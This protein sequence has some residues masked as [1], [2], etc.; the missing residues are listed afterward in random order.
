MLNLHLFGCIILSEPDFPYP[1]KPRPEE[2]AY[3]SPEME[4]PP[5]PPSPPPPPPLVTENVSK[6]TCQI[7][8]K[9]FSTEEELNMHMKTEHQNPKKK[10]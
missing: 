1:K 6:Y 8:G 2:T 4:Y 10:Y 3:V 7:C 9:T 5:A